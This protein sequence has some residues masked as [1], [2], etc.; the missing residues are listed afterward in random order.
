ML[1]QTLFF[2]GGFLVG[3]LFIYLIRAAKIAALNEQLAA[4][5]NTKEKLQND[6]KV[7]A[8]EALQNANQQF[9]SSAMKDL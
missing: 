3:A 4:E 1:L 8:S 9:L 7:A 6:F 5:K 2:A